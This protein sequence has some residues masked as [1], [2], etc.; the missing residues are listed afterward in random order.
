MP[1]DDNAEEGQPGF[2]PPPHPDDRLWRHPS[3]LR[4]YPIVPLGAPGRPPRA[5]VP[6]ERGHPWFAVVAAGTVGAVLAGIGVV[7]LG[8]GERVVDRPVIER[9]ALDPVAA[10]PGVQ[11]AQ[12]HD[13]R[14]LVTPGVVGI[15]TPVATDKKGDGE[16]VGSGVVVRNDGIVVTS[17]ALL[18]GGD[19]WVRLADGNSVVG[20]VV[21]TDPVTGLG[22]LDLQGGGYTPSVLAPHGDLMDGETS[23]GVTARLAG[24]TTT[25][26]GLVGE[27][28]RYV[29]PSGA[30][31]DGVEVA[32]KPERL[33]LG[34][35]L[36]D[37][38][39][40]V[41]GVT[42]AV[43]DDSWYVMP[44]EVV[45]KVTNDLLRDGRVHGCWLGI[46]GMDVP[47]PTRAGSTSGG[48]TIVTSVVDDSP[49]A[50]GGLRVGDTVVGLDE[51]PIAEMPALNVAL[52]AHSPG[53]HVDVQ[54]HRPDGATVTLVL[55]L[56]EQK[57]RP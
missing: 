34:G 42:A 24:G 56:T 30:A 1:F 55:T 11:A 25:A 10:A 57:L 26:P 41:V 54:V 20:D 36:A 31:I 14:R 27:P 46:E 53:D 7:A 8:I 40:A 13:I 28:Q 18:T 2:R 35:V 12:V 45:N 38:R 52:R 17:G 19:V 50:L 21:G 39:G 9:V 22:V 33:A 48:G 44:V 4:Q 16:L 29:G 32:G 43:D 51:R 6:A 5:R 15:G 3:E 23:Y 37:P 49:A 47:D